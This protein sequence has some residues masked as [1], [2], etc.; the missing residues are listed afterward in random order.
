[1]ADTESDAI[2][3]GLRQLDTTPERNQS[4]YG[5][6]AL[7]DAL[8]P[9]GATGLPAARY[10]EKGNAGIF[11]HSGYQR[12]GRTGSDFRPAESG[13]GGGNDGLSSGLDFAQRW[14]DGSWEDS[15]PRVATGIENRA[16][17]LKALGNAVVPQI[18]ELIGR[19]IL[20]YE[21]QLG[22]AA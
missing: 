10:G 22:L 13:L 11:D 3:T 19:A 14:T 6:K 17:R 8:C 7:A 21:Q 20:A 2:R 5:S 15:I 1:M 9:R 18:P 4:C 12:G 16:Q